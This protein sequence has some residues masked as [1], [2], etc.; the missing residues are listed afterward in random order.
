V[1]ILTL[2]ILIRR[3]DLRARL[4]RLLGPRQMNTMTAAIDQAAGRVSRYLLTQ[5]SVN[6]GYEVLFGLGLYWIGVPYAP[7]WGGIAAVLRFISYV[8][9]LIAGAY[10]PANIETQLR[11]KS[12]S[13]SQLRFIR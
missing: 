7:F 13:G 1:V 10:I 11:S 8:G 9:V 4:F 3:S 2:F 12:L 5:S 6:S